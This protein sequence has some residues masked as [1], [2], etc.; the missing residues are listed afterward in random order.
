MGFVALSALLSC[1]QDRWA[2]YYPYTGRALWIDSVM[3]AE[4]LWY[5]DIPEFNDLNYFNTPSTFLSNAKSSKD[6]YS[7]VDTIDYSLDTGY[8]FDFTTSSADV[9]DTAYF[10]LVTYVMPGS[11]ADEAGME[12][13]DWVMQVDGAYFTSKGDSVLEDGDSRTLLLGRYTAYTE[14][15]SLGNETTD[16]V[17]VEDRT[18]T[19]PAV[20]EV[21]DAVIPVSTILNGSVGYLVYNS[22]DADY[23]EELLDFADLCASS[24][25]SD[26]VLDLRYNEGGDMG[27]VEL[28]A[29]LLAPSSAMGSTLASLEYSDIRTEKDCDLTLDAS[30]LNGHSALN[31]STLYV[32]T[33]ANTSAAAEMLIHCLDPHMSVVVIGRTT[34]GFY[35]ATE[36]FSSDYYQWVLHLVTCYVYNASGTI[37]SSSGISP[38]YSINHL[39]DPATVLPLGDPDEALLSVAL[40]YIDGTID[41]DAKALGGSRTTLKSAPHAAT[42]TEA[43]TEADAASADASSARRSRS[44]RHSFKR[45]LLLHR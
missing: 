4:Y 36:D 5:A 26:F 33:T 38:D 43:G 16:Y 19:L 18:V 25:V 30:L 2:E 17:V 11:P 15:D 14:T 8:G 29:A 39:S 6:S 27:S 28:L 20:R 44:G 31:L 42:V 12:R 37:M 45:G 3:R 13:G 21:E 24:G 34:D 1:G 9:N 7:S 10:A 32:L 35:V 23:D 41:S 40:S 22:F